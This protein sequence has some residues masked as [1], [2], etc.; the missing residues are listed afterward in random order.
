MQ[1]WSQQAVFYHIYPLGLCGAPRHNDFNSLVVPRLAKVKDWLEHI[2]ALGANT[3]YIGPLFESSRHGY[4]TADYYRVDRRL[5]S[6]ETL[7]ML[8]AD[9]HA[10]GMRLV[11]DGV[12][13]H[14][15]RD[16][17][18]FR[19]VLAH[20][21]RSAYCDW[22]HNLRFEGRSPRND[23]FQYEGWNGHYSLV[24]LNLHNPAVR[25]HLFGAVRS[26]VRDYQIGG[27]RLDAAD[28]LDRDFLKALGGFC[29]GLRADF[30]LMGEV[31]H[32]DYRQWA[33]PQM[34]DSVTNYECYNGLYSSHLDQNFFEIA[35]ALKRQFGEGGIYRGVN[36]YNFADNHDV[37]RVA[38]RLANPAHLRTLY[39]LLLTMPGAPSIYYGSEWGIRGERNTLSDE[40]LRPELDLQE[41]IHNPP[42]TDLPGLIAQLARVRAGSAAL[43]HGDYQEL[44]VGNEQLAF[45][46]RTDNEQ[47]VVVINAGEEPAQLRFAVPAGG[48][49]LVDLLDANYSAKVQDGMVS[50]EVGACRARILARILR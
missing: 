6:N 37:N 32:G 24:K 43:R 21:E 39:S 16:F 9:L 28:C 49:K 5:G 11:L 33:N 40:A 41:L 12:F 17:W 26:W 29:R 7:Q 31:V 45:Q 22:F 20:G 47:V 4:D 1:Q 46:R 19:D 15:G 13:N 35:Q 3:L 38:S 30:W 36:L 14:V 23:P 44:M 48:G 34:L 27:L 2:Q 10:R 8:S 50:V 18:A 25:E 42:Q